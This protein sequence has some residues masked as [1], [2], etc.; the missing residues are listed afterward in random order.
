MRSNRLL[1]R[2]VPSLF[3]L[4]VRQLGTYTCR[5]SCQASGAVVRLSRWACRVAWR[6]TPAADSPAVRRLSQQYFDAPLELRRFL[7]MR[8]I[9]RV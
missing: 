9:R 2:R 8:S 6:K 1:P 3:E 7:R 5:Q 4:V